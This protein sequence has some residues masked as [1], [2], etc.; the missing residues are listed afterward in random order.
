MCLKTRQSEY[1]LQDFG[2]RMVKRELQKHTRNNRFLNQH[3]RKQI[4]GRTKIQEKSRY[5][6]VADLDPKLLGLLEPIELR[7]LLV[8]Q[9]IQNFN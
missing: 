6:C 7:Q 1:C 5:D 4:E 2:P 9:I 3:M 8:S